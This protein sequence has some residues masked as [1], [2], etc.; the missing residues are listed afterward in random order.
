M[1]HGG[2]ENWDCKDDK[3]FYNADMDNTFEIEQVNTTICT[4]KYKDIVGL[5][6][7]I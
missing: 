3:T 2:G 6:V 4:V 5:I 1:V 7:K